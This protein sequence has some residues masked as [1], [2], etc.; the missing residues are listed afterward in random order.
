M[1]LSALR[2]LLTVRHCGVSDIDTVVVDSLK[3][4]DPEWPIREADIVREAA[5]LVDAADLPL[6]GIHHEVGIIFAD[7][8]AEAEAGPAHGEHGLTRRVLH[9]DPIR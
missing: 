1:A 9:L 3:A 5:A 7:A 6:A 2:N 8:E 4:L